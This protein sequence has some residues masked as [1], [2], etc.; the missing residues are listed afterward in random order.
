MPRPLIYIFNFWNTNAF[1]LHMMMTMMTRRRMKRRSS[2][3]VRR[4]WWQVDEVEV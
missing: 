1:V 2:L 4:R 3:W